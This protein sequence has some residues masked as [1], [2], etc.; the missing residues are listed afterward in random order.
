MAR[1][2]APYSEL[3]FS[4]SHSSCHIAHSM[5]L[6]GVRNHIALHSSIASAPLLLARV[7]AFIGIFVV[8]P[9]LECLHR[10]KFPDQFMPW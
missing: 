4:S 10:N 8:T 6:L 2:Y 5:L 9:L 3:R 7:D 1:C